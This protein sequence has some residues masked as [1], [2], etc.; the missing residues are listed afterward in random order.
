M[1]A[2]LALV[3]AVLAT[4]ASAIAPACLTAQQRGNVAVIAPPGDPLASVT[5]TFL[6][7]AT[8]FP[9]PGPIRITLQVAYDPTFTG[10]LAVDTTLITPLSAIGIAPSVALGSGQK[11]WYRAI[12]TDV[13]GVQA[14]SAIAGPKTIPPWVTPIGP[15][16]VV[17]QPVRTRTPR[18]VWHSP[19]INNPPGPWLYTIT[20]TNVGLNI[21]KVTPLG[22]DTTFV[23]PQDLEPNAFYTWSILARPQRST[24]ASRADSPTPF[25]IE[26]ADTPIAITTLYAPFPSPFPS[27]GR[28][29]TCLW[30]DLEHTST[31]TLDVYDL[32][33]LHVRR[34]LPNAEFGA[35]VSPGRYGRGRTEFNE[36]CDSRFA[37]DGTDERGRTVPEGVYLVRFRGDGVDLTKKVVFRGRR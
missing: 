2:R 28:N 37:W 22:S 34:I 33:G 1:F 16:F 25:L 30:F 6:V 26:D 24:Q 4:V 32:R 29:T 11:I 12:A 3:I 35:T 17:G 13:N 31:V 8:D 15:P 14:T 18:F 27:I 20:I 10:T 7:Q 21:P 36:N 9:N 23:P 19:Q 5:P